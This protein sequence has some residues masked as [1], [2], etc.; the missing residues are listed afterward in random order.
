MWTPENQRGIFAKGW[1]ARHKIYCTGR[2]DSSFRSS[3]ATITEE[4]MFTFKPTVRSTTPLKSALLWQLPQHVTE[5]RPMSASL[6]HINLDYRNRPSKWPLSNCILHSWNSPSFK[7]PYLDWLLVLSLGDAP[8]R[9][10]FFSSTAN[11]GVCE[12][13]CGRHIVH[14]PLKAGPVCQ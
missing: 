12:L 3:L 7:L 13:S 9:V 4:S 1:S 14:L 8:T 2:S 6:L 11:T 5:K 10:S